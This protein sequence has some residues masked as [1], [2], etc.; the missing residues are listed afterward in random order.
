MMKK[1]LIIEDTPIHLKKLKEILLPKYDIVLSK[2]GEKGIELAL[3]NKI[4]LILLDILLPGMS[5]YEVLDVLKSKEETKDIP[6]IFI[7]SMDSENEEQGLR[8]GIVDCIPK[9]F[10]DDVVSERV[11]L[12]L[13]LST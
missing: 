3:D 2:T 4:D 8:S 11:D 10:V 13:K 6:V 9:P 7:T 12:Q 1:I 5:G